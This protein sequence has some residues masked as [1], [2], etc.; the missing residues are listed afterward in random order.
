[1]LG[2]SP[3]ASSALLASRTIALLIPPRA[4]FLSYDFVL[5]YILRI[6]IALYGYKKNNMRVFI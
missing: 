1:M 6:Y 2:F 5:F 3:R 4:I